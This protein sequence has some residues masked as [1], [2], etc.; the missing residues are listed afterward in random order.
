MTTYIITGANRGI[1]FALAKN[2]S[3][4]KNNKVV[5]TTRSLN[6]AQQLKDLNRDNIEIIELDVTHSVET[7]KNCLAKLSFLREF[8]VDTVVHNAGISILN[9]TPIHLEPIETFEKQWQ[10]NTLASVKFYQAIYPYWTEANDNVTKKAI[11]ISS[12]VGSIGA[13]S[14]P[15]K[16]YGLSKAGLNFL[17]KHIAVENSRSEIPTLRDS[18]ALAVHPGLVLTDMAKSSADSLE[19]L[20]PF[21][22]MPD[23]SA[24]NIVKII[25]EAKKEQTGAFLSN[26][27]STIPY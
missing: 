11:F 3:A 8:G 9:D 2:I 12:M 15:T 26:D 7:Q 19:E 17:V 13:L 14:F 18:V 6:R 23:V 27:G 25:D 4:T 5:A 24:E 22:I 20:R 16:G 1:G 10:N 21:V